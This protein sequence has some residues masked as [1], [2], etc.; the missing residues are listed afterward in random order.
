VNAP[1]GKP[2]EADPD[3]ATRAYHDFLRTAKRYWAHDLYG[4]LR[5]EFEARNAVTEFRDADAIEHALADSPL[6]RYFGWFE[7]NLQR[8][9]YASPRGILATVERERHRLEAQLASATIEAERSGQLRLT[10]GF[11][12]P[13]YY[14]SVEFHQHPGGVW[15]DSLAGVAYDF[16]RR[17]T[18]PLHA[19]ADDLHRRF[20]ARAPHGP[21]RRILDL[22]CG[23]GR[24][25]LPF[26]ALDSGA[27]LHGID[28]SAPCLRS[29]WIRARAAGVD[30]R[31]AQQRAEHT[32][33]PD[34]HFGLVHSTFLLHELPKPALREIVHEALRVLE[35]GGWFVNL[36]F[37]SPPGGAW[38][39]FIHYGH[40]R[41]NEEVFMRSFCETDFVAMQLEAGFRE[42]RMEP[43]DDGS[44]VFDRGTAPPVWR[45]PAQLFIAR[46]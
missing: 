11:E 1:T 12:P 17:T 28:L 15:R 4:A 21:F 13:R 16:G 29:A 40:A 45:F 6:Y 5:R 34:A 31:W 35:P 20:A 8:L 14:T 25:T 33:F 22:G 18:M 30:V 38:G 42:A 2:L 19:D 36:D 9:K 10:A 26:G 37:H 32:G 23:T 43:F 24:S 3:R 7:R 39:D 46:K 44:G 27:E 41:R